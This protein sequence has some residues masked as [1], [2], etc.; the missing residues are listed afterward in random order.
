MEFIE[1][2]PSSLLL[3]CYYCSFYDAMHSLRLLKGNFRLGL[4][5]GPH[6]APNT[7]VCHNIVNTV[8]VS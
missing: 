4:T 7:F 1:G 6:D 8:C 2:I 3:Y 5:R